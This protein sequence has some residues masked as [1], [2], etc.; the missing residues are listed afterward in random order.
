MTLSVDCKMEKDS[1]NGK[2]WYEYEP[3]LI[4]KS[5][6]R[7]VLSD[8]R[9]KDLGN[10]NYTVELLAEELAVPFVNGEEEKRC[11]IEKTDINTYDLVFKNY[12]FYEKWSYI[13]YI[14]LILFIPLLILSL[15]LI[16]VINRN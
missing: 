11:V 12:K 6:K 5:R 7:I 13:T 9:Q 4:T 1:N 3:I 2:V 16:L 10:L 15:F 8:C 14:L